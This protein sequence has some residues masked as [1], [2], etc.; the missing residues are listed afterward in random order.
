MQS[1][2]PSVVLVLVFGDSLPY[3]TAFTKYGPMDVEIYICAKREIS[4][5]WSLSMFEEARA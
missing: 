4:L 5:S 3:Y 2:D 1:S